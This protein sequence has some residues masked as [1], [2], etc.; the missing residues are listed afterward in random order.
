MNFHIV[1]RG[2]GV[3]FNFGFPIGDEVMFKL[4]S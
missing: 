2:G 3:A 1:S 4:F